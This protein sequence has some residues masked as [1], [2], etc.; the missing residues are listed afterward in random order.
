MKIL[1]LIAN[2]GQGSGG[3]Y[4]SLNQISKSLSKSIDL[5][6]VSIGS[7]KSALLSEN[8]NFHDHIF[9]SNISQLLSLK[10]SFKKVLS[11][12]K[13]DILHFFDT[14]SLNS[15]LLVHSLKN[16]PVVLNK[17]GGQNPLRKKWQFAHDLILFS[18][19]NHDFFVNNTSASKDMNLHLIAAR[20]KAVDPTNLFSHPEIKEKNTVTFLRV[21][22][23]GGAYEKTLLDSYNLIEKLNKDGIKVKLIVVGRIQNKER[24]NLL[25]KEAKSR[26]L[27]VSFITDQRAG[28]GSSFLYLADIVIGTG[29]SLMEG[30]STG[31]PCLVPL[32]NLNIPVL[33]D[34]QSFDTLFKTN[35]SERGT[36]QTNFEISYKKIKEVI[37]DQKRYEDCSS[38]SNKTFKSTFDIEQS[39]PAYR[40]IYANCLKQK[41]SISL[42]KKNILYLFKELFSLLKTR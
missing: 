37:Q 25:V 15:I 19:E 23:L 32:S 16:F 27:L 42:R 18:K 13:P 11:E 40:K 1:F 35:F 2:Y 21:S 9:I 34:N 30:M 8:I 20:V 6:I 39:L 41:T 36:F 29:R 4:H 17:C 26:H 5:N 38:F 24:F 14:D 31:K 12:L 28:K 10:S 22:R 7:K 33:V 3:H